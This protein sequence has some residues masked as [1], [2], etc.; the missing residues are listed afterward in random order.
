MVLVQ[1]TRCMLRQHLREQSCQF[2][3]KLVSF[4]PSITAVVVSRNHSRGLHSVCLSVCHT[5]ELRRHYIHFFIVALLPNTGHGLLILE[6]FYTTHNDAAQT[7][8]LLWTSDELVAQT[9]T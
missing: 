2:V 6:V 4:P 8:G 1:P 9:S 3:T 7:V 5:Q